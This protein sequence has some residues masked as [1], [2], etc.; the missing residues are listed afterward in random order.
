MSPGFEMRCGTRSISCSGGGNS[1]V[2][3]VHATS[4]TVFECN[5]RFK[6]CIYKKLYKCSLNF[7]VYFILLVI[8][9]V[10]LNTLIHTFQFYVLVLNA[11]FKL[12]ILKHKPRTQK[13]VSQEIKARGITKTSRNI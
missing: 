8:T 9:T 5:S 13:L 12:C 6:C 11:C 4:P 2:A 7:A 3:R 1:S 10:G